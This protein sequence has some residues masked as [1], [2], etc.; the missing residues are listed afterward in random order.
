MHR[1]L[2]A[3]GVLDDACVERRY[4]RILVRAASAGAVAAA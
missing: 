4:L 2:R 1:L 3:R